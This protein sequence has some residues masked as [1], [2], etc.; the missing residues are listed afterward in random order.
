MFS[1]EHITNADNLTIEMLYVFSIRQGIHHSLEW[2]P[3][4]ELGS[5]DGSS[6]P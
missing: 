1:K 3:K 5:S 4:E 6:D 2:F